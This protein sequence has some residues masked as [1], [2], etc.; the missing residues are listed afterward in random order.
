MVILN[1]FREN[2]PQLA[3]LKRRK[4]RKR[5]KKLLAVPANIE[6]MGVSRLMNKSQSDSAWENKIKA[7]FHIRDMLLHWR[8]IL[9]V[10]STFLQNRK[11]YPLSIILMTFPF[12]YLV[13][14]F[15]LSMLCCLTITG[16]S[17]AISLQ[18]I[19]SSS[20][21]PCTWK[22]KTLI[23]W[24]VYMKLL[25]FTLKILWNERKDSQLKHYRHGIYV[26]QLFTFGRLS[27]AE[28]RTSA[29]LCGG[30]S[31]LRSQAAIFG[32][33]RRHLRHTEKTKGK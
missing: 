10:T 11:L 25:V 19:Q 15:T 12:S 31:G 8:L 22:S 28:F 29:K 13:H 14:S 9:S 4:E 1:V 30:W 5:N 33:K 32:S 18:T 16:P 21:P 3:L 2:I 20:F 7:V 24:A 17:I 26:M 27:W 23:S 6:Q